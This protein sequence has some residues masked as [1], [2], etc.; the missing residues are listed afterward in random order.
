MAIHGPAPGQTPFHK[1]GIERLQVTLL[2]GFRH[3]AVHVPKQAKDAGRGWVNHL[4]KSMA[5]WPR[6]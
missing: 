4:L 6:Q 1:G 5:T 2:L 3:G